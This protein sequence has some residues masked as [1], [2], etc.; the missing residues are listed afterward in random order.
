MVTRVEVVNKILSNTFLATIVT[1]TLSNHI[2]DELNAFA[3][4]LTESGDEFSQVA[5][6]RRAAKIVQMKQEQE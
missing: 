4:A 1:N 2:A 6:I 5:G 3:D